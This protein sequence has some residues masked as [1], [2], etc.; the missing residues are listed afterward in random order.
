M[1]SLQTTFTWWKCAT[2][3][4]KPQ[5][6]ISTVTANIPL[7]QQPSK[8]IQPTQTLLKMCC[9]L[10]LCSFRQTRQ[11]LCS[12]LTHGHAYGRQE[13]NISQKLCFWSLSSWK[14]YRSKI[15][16]RRLLTLVD[17]VCSIFKVTKDLGKSFCS[18]LEFIQFPPLMELLHLWTQVSTSLKTMR[19]QTFQATRTT[20]KYIKKLKNNN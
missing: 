9:A 5:Q 4:Y 16:E 17:A 1:P 8:S 2:L 19:S 14:T 6:C 13:H 7:L 20:E 11:T 3:K 10:I 18:P 15:K 12:Q